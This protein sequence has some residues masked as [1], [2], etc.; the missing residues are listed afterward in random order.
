[1]FRTAL[2]LA[3]V[4]LGLVAAVPPPYPTQAI[5]P[6]PEDVATLDGIL[7][8]FY[9]VVS[10]PAGTPRQWARDR[11]LYIPE[12]RFAET[13]RLPDGGVRTDVWDHPHFARDTDAFAFRDGFFEKEIHRTTWTWGGIAHVLSTYESRRTADGPII[14]RGVNSIELFWDGKR[15]WIA[16]AIWQPEQPG[17]PIPEELLPSKPTR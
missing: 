17:L 16:T 12:V 11:T 7:L 14:A 6:R 13:R 3:L 1:M 5:P 4:A 9:D 2:P 10:G 15:W 8:A